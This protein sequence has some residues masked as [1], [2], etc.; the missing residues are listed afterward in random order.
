MGTS[1]TAA[2]RHRLSLS[3]IEA[4]EKVTRAEFL[5]AA[6]ALE[7]AK[8]EAEDRSIDLQAML[9][10]YIAEH[11]AVKEKAGL[12]KEQAERATKAR[13]QVIK[14]LMD[15]EAEHR[16]LLKKIKDHKQEMADAEGCL[17]RADTVRA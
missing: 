11:K 12:A 1:K 6:K 16:Q 14:E 3:P 7:Q 8:R 13:D 5:E 4:G 17:R 2:K 9:D 10:N 15:K